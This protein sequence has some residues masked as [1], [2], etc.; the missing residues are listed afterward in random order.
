MRSS[1]RYGGCI[2]G[3]RVHQVYAGEVA[4]A[5]S[6]RRQATQAAD[7]ERL[8]RE[9]VALQQPDQ[10]VQADALAADHHEI[11]RRQTGPDQLH[12]TGAPAGTASVSAGTAKN[13]SAWAKLVT[14][15]EP[16][17]VG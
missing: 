15:P 12:P 17:A 13:P 9:A 4:L 1:V 14:A 11:G 16:F 6:R 10:Q 3:L 7:G 5:A 8:H 2:A